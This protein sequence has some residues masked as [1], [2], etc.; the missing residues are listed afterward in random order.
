MKFVGGRQ[1]HIKFVLRTTYRLHVEE[2]EEIS[3]VPSIS[4]FFAEVGIPFFF[5]VNLI[6]ASFHFVNGHY[7]LPFDKMVIIAAVIAQTKFGDWRS[8]F[9]YAYGILYGRTYNSSER[10]SG[11]APHHFLLNHGKS[12]VSEAVCETHR[13]FTTKSKLEIFRTYHF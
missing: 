9:D 2:E 13:N 10:I 8:D 1:S 3:D 4:L 12:K 5:L 11:L 6:Q 7:I